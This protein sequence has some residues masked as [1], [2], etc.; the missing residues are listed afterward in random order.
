MEVGKEGNNRKH[1][2]GIPVITEMELALG[3]G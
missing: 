3:K 2:E 1:K